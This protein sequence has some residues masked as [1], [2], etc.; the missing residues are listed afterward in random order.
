MHNV[1]G[2]AERTFEAAVHRWVDDVCDEP[3]ATWL[4]R[5]VQR[6]EPHAR[7]DALGQKMLALTVP[8]VRTS[9]RAPRCGRTALS[10]RTTVGRSIFRAA[11]GN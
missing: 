10:I 9:T 8:G 3:V 6:L 5:L 7:S 4:T 11:V 2:G 1:L